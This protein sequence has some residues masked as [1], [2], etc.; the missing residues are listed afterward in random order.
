MNKLVFIMGVII[1]LISVIFAIIYAL[2]SGY[3]TG[4]TYDSIMLY[5]HVAT[6]FVFI[7]LFL[8]IIGILI[9]RPPSIKSVFR[10]TKS[11]FVLMIAIVNATATY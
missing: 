10:V 6:V 1:T 2:L 7:G 4:S 9:R 3:V 8:I 11:E 5:Q